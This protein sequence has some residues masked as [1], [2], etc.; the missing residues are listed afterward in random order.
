[1]FAEVFQSAREE[2]LLAAARRGLRYIETNNQITF[3]APIIPRV[4][5]NSV[6]IHL[7]RHP[8]DFV[9]SGV[10]RKWYTGNHSHDIGRIVPRSGA[11]AKEWDSFSQVAKIGWL[12]NETNRFIEEFAKQQPERCLTLKAEGLFAA[13]EES[14][15][16]FD[17]LELTGYNR[18]AVDRIIQ[19]PANPQRK[20]SFPKYADWKDED[21]DALQR[22][23]PL[24]VKYGYE[25]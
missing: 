17:F 23:A 10:R 16:V 4:F 6:F 11:L 12:W 25:L 1:L 21:R 2:Y 24:A 15:R 9:R 22:V 14:K 3:F 18:K 8:A 20:G 7:V 19:K 13:T 5:P